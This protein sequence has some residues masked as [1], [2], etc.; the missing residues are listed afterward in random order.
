MDPT[1]NPAED[2]EFDI[3]AWEMRQQTHHAWLAVYQRRCLADVQKPRPYTRGSAR[4]WAAC[5]LRGAAAQ[6]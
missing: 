3:N 2:P 5:T 4:P 1:R 6:P